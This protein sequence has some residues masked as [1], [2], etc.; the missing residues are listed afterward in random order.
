[1]RIARTTPLPLHPS[2]A[3]FRH[4]ARKGKTPV[5]GRRVRGGAAEPVDAHAGQNAGLQG[6]ESNLIEAALGEPCPYL[7]G[8][9]GRAPVP[10]PD[11]GRARTARGRCRL[12][13]APD[14]GDRSRLP[15]MPH[16]NSTSAGSAS[17]KLAARLAS[18]WRTSTWNSP[19]PAAAWPTGPALR[20]S[21]STPTLWLP[22]TAL[23]QDWLPS[24]IGRSALTCKDVGIEPD[25]RESV[26]AFAMQEVKDHL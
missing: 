4:A 9:V 21:A 15:K 22:E 1:M 23:R 18:A 7:R 8:Q 20:T 19:C 10:G 11:H 14:V 16:S 25:M 13:G 3:L 2:A 24:A 26:A 5:A 6:V 17:A 12:N